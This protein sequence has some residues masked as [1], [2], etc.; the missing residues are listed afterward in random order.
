MLVTEALTAPDE[1]FP[2]GPL[3]I[4]FTHAAWVEALVFFWRAASLV[5]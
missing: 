4:G 2:E 3:V 1:H 5:A